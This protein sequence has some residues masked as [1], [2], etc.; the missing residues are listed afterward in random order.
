MGQFIVFVQIYHSYSLE[1][2]GS[3]LLWDEVKELALHEEKA[4]PT[5]SVAKKDGERHA[6]RHSLLMGPTVPA[7]WA[8]F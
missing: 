8:S 2:K 7:A 5:Q 4:R 1:G 6:A 3:V